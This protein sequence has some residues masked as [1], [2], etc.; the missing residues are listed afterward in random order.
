[1]KLMYVM[2]SPPPADG[3]G[4]QLD[5]RGLTGE[6]VMST[7]MTTTR[8]MMWMLLQWKQH[9]KPTIDQRRVWR[10]DDIVD[11]IWNQVMSTSISASVA[12]MR[13]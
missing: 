7:G 4:P 5:L 9:R 1:M 12:M 10:T 6:A 11:L 8:S 3:D 2:S 13:M